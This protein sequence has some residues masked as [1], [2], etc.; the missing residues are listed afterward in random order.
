MKEVF[1]VTLTGYTFLNL[2]LCFF[3]QEMSR[4]QLYLQLRRDILEERS[5]CDEDKVMTQAGLALQ[6]EYGDYVQES[7][8]RTYFVP[9]HY[10]PEHVVKRLGSGYIRQHAPDAHKMHAGMTEVEAKIELIKVRML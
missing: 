6:A 4:N 7:M 3:R 5:L 8:G 2:Y 1:R 9:E 10:F